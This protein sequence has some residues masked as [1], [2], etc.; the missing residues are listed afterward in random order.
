MKPRKQPKT[1]GFYFNRMANKFAAYLSI[2]NV[3][4]HLGLFKTAEEARQAHLNARERM[5]NADTK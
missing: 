2:N 1:R 3:R 4:H 5:C